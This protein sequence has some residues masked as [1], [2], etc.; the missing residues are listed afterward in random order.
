MYFD[1]SAE[2]VRAYCPDADATELRCELYCPD[3]NA[4]LLGRCELYWGG[5]LNRNLRLIQAS[6]TFLGRMDLNFDILCVLIF[7]SPDSPNSKIPSSKRRRAGVVRY[8]G[9]RIRACDVMPSC[10]HEHRHHWYL[11]F[12]LTEY[13]NILWDHKLHSPGLIS[14]FES[15][16]KIKNGLLKESHKNVPN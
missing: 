1:Q 8:I 7:R 14:T 2:Q 12:V 6:S 15:C 16:P 4:N 3:V 5:V 10:S 13:P 9:S 11:S